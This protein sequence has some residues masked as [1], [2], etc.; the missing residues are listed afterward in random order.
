MFYHILSISV[1][2]SNE[3]DVV[4][5]SEVVP[6]PPTSQNREC[7]PMDQAHRLMNTTEPSPQQPTRQKL[8]RLPVDQDVK[9]DLAF[10]H[11]QK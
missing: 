5:L 4:V 9:S 8:E 11:P 6:R 2:N 7:S 1:H 3:P 10:G